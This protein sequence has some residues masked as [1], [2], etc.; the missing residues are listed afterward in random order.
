[1]FI[2]KPFF[3]EKRY[4]KIHVYAH[5]LLW[6]FFLN[7]NGRKE[8]EAKGMSHR[9]HWEKNSKQ[10]MCISMTFTFFQWAKNR[11]WDWQLILIV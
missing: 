5:Y 10:M 6:N 4:Q 3:L 1:M 2:Y 7:D 11:K 8:R 9:S